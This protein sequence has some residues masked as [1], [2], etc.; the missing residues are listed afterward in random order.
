MNYLVASTKKRLISGGI[1]FAIIA[2]ITIPATYLLFCI[3]KAELLN[4]GVYRDLLGNSLLLYLA[5]ATALLG[6]NWAYLR[7]GQTIGMKLMGTKVIMAN[8]EPATFVTVVLR[9]IVYMMSEWIVWGI[10]I[11][12]LALMIFHPKRRT[13]HDLLAGTIVVDC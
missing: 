11:V 1:D 9:L 12:N 2:V 3:L 10:R 7:N 13:V 8:G 6:F 4:F 5:E